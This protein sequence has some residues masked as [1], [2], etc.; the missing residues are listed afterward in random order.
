MTAVTVDYPPNPKVDRSQLPPGPREWPIV[1][2]TWRY[3]TNTIGLMQEAATYGDLATLSARPALAY[4]VNHPDLI[5]EVLVTQHRRGGTGSLQRYAQVPAGRG[6]DYIG[7]RLSL[8]AAPP[9]A[10]ALPQSP[11]CRLRRDHAP[12]HAASPSRAGPM[13]SKWTW[14]RRCRRSRCTLWSRPCSNLDLPSEVYRI[15]RAFDISNH[16]LIVP[17]APTPCHSPRVPSAAAAANQALST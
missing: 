3:L 9:D 15:G 12:V 6:T 5:Q 10:T 11:H 2:Q 8:A 1:G 4:L 7:R 17:S 16:Y 14:P 13:A